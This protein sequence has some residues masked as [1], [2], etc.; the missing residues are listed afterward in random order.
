MTSNNRRGGGLAERFRQ[1]SDSSLKGRYRV[2]KIHDQ[3]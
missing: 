3:L 1:N 2:L